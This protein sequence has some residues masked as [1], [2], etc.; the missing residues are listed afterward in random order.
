MSLH[1]YET[2]NLS[3]NIKDFLGFHKPSDLVLTNA[4]TLD[5][6]SPSM[7]LSTCQALCRATSETSKLVI[8]EPAGVYYCTP[9]DAACNL[10]TR[11]IC[12]K[13]NLPKYVYNY[14]C[15]FASILIHINV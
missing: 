11:C 14:L 9:G 13:G 6:R 12:A 10:N 1:I 5:V 2:A 7:T 15:I 3:F 4:V 8:V